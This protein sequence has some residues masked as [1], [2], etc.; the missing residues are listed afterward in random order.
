MNIIRTTAPLI[1]ITLFLTACNTDQLVGGLG[2]ASGTGVEAEAM[3]ARDNLDLQRVGALLERS[4]N[5]QEFE[6]YLNEDDGINNLDLNGDGYVD[7]ISVEEFYDRDDYGRGL[8]LY[9][10]FGPDLIQE[11]ATIVFYRDEPSWPGARV[12]VIGNDNIYGDNVYYETNW[13]DRPIGLIQYVYSVHDPYRSPYYYGYYPPDYVVYEVVETPVYVTRVRTFYP[14]PVLVYTESPTFISKVK[15]KS[16]NR[17]KHFDRVFAKLAKP[18]REQEKFIAENRGK[19]PE[20][21]KVDRPGQGKKDSGPGPDKFRSA[22][23]PRGH[24]KV[25]VAKQPHGQ[26]HQPVDVQPQQQMRQPKHGKPIHPASANPQGH[27]KQ[28]HSP[29]PAPQVAKAAP[30]GGKHGNPGQGGGKGKKP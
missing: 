24:D 1:A 21:V 3:W 14:E 16:P 26:K 11:I 8:S 30:Q 25:K 17:G 29:K 5:P 20:S 2:P 18:T 22:D 28:M 7:Y 15:I 13:Y 19:K 27:N 12:V 6:E 9:S 4:D 10:R 23:I